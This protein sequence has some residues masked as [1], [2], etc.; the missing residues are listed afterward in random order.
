MVLLSHLV[1]VR[2]CA[3]VGLRATGEAGCSFPP[4]SAL[5]YPLTSPSSMAGGAGTVL[6]NAQHK[7]MQYD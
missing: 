3:C 4:L 2:A 1:R 6:G 7:A 5:A